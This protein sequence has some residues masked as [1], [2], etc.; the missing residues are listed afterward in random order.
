MDIVGDS[1]LAR[2]VHRTSRARTLDQF[3]VATTLNAHDDP[4]VA[5]CVRLGVHCLRGAEMDVLDRYRAVAAMID[6]E[7]VVRITADCPFIEPRLIDQVVAAFHTNGADYA[8]NTQLRSWPRGLDV[9]VFTR[10]ALE[11]AWTEA[12]EP[13]QRAH[14]TPYLYQHPELFRI[15]AVVDTENHSNLRWTVDT[16]EDLMLTRM[17]YEYLDGRDDFDWREALALVEQIPKLSE[18]NQ[19]VRQKS[20][21]QG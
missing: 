3:V 10:A 6:A 11:R 17:I 19:H 2:V 9:E 16:N 8:S 1:L 21:E 18:L 13:W 15:H 14:V 20:L 5:E 7:V 4:I 12:Q